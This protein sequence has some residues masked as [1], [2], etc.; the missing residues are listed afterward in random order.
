MFRRCCYHSCVSQR[1]REFVCEREIEVR[2]QRMISLDDKYAAL[3]TTFLPLLGDR[4]TSY[5]TAEIFIDEGQEWSPWD[6][7]PIRLYWAAGAVTSVSWT[8]FDELILTPDES[9]LAW[10]EESSQLRWVKNGLSKLNF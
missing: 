7:L 5:A 3:R 8:K 1:R 4:L 2:R 6:D 10:L 9:L